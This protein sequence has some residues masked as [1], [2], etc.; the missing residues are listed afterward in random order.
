MASQSD[1]RPEAPATQPVEP[2]ELAE[3]PQREK[4]HSSSPS[5]DPEPTPTPRRE[6]S[7]TSYDQI[8]PA[9][10]NSTL[11]AQDDGNVMLSTD[12]G[13]LVEV[14]RLGSE[15][16]TI[17]EVP[18]VN[19]HATSLLSKPPLRAGTARSQESEDSKD[20][21]W[22]KIQWT[23]SN[24]DGQP[25]IH[26]YY[27]SVMIF[28]ALAGFVGAIG[29]HLYNLRLD[30]KEVHD[31]AWPQRWGVALAF[32]VKMMLG[33]AVQIA[34]KQRAWVCVPFEPTLFRASMLN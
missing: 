24:G 27:P 29:H 34:F 9:P 26:W 3:D 18:S 15:A 21:K 11:N 12:Q 20:Q 4:I 14:K 13:L 30:G 10:S 16:E 2:T 25:G 5:S 1:Q 32:F 31:P 6:L 23:S 33:A 28:L 22:P 7:P 19:G 17:T 8:S